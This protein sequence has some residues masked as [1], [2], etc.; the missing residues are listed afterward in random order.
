MPYS[1]GGLV[2]IQFCMG[3]VYIVC[4]IRFGIFLGGSKDFFLH[5]SRI[6][7]VLLVSF[8]RSLFLSGAGFFGSFRSRM[9]IR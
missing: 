8:L 2:R 7:L 1:R 5:C 6:R 4:R 9:G 3:P